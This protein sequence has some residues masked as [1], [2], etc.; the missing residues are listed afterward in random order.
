MTY[1]DF[2]IE[3]NINKNKHCLFVSPHLDDAIFSA[4]GIMYELNKSGNKITVLNVFTKVPTTKPSLS[5]NAFIKQCG[6]KSANELYAQRAIEDND[7][8]KQVGANIINANFTEALWREKSK[9]SKLGEF[10]PEFNLIYPTYRW[11]IKRGEVKTEDKN[12][13]NELSM[14]IT[15]LDN[16]EHFDII[17][18]PAGVGNHIDHLVVKKAVEE[19]KNKN[20]IFWEDYP[21]ALKEDSFDFDK[22][23][24]K[25]Y[26]VKI[27]W[28]TKLGLIKFYNSQF[29]AVFAENQPKERPETF[30]SKKV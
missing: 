7:A 16:N 24:F 4:G 6:Y 19:I 22:K 10:I 15:N 1:K 29:N 28:E 12:T 13:I 17:F 20:V 5:A 27:D 18:A 21:Y 23:H 30:L 3:T 11:H 9:S 14:L 25:K 2:I 26:E 8:L